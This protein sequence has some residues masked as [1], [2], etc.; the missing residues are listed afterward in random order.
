MS[1][2]ISRLI[3]RTLALAFVTI[4]ILYVV[5][6]NIVVIVLSLHKAQYFSFPPKEYSLRWYS[7]ALFRPEWRNAFLLSIWLA[8]LTSVCSSIIGLLAGLALFRY[9]IPGKRLI[10]TLFLSP[11]IMPGILI[12]L[13]AL[14]FL[15]QL[16][17]NG[18]FTALLLGHILVTFPYVLRLVLSA[19]PSVSRSMEEAALTLGADELTTLWLVTLPTIRP[20][21]LSGALFA[22]ILS[23]DNVMVSLFLSNARV[24]TLPVKILH[25][26]EWA[27]DP[28]IAAIS[29]IFMI[30]SL[31]LMITI[32]RTVG[33]RF[34]QTIGGQR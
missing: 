9:P 32:D 24:A 3:G 8:F 26:L 12:G 31:V 6:P 18:T 19:L 1:R 21:V 27:S 13:A 23:F 2:G 14:F 34:G 28:T 22:F 16:G 30:M 20:A 11:L 25:V 10:S 29:T 4:I 15:S 7:E 17:L 5:L 33:L